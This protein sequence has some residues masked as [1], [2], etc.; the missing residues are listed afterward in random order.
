MKLLIHADIFK[1]F[2]SYTTYMV[3]NLKWPFTQAQVAKTIET[4]IKNHVITSWVNLPWAITPRRKEIH[5]K[6]HWKQ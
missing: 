2:F 5:A 1:L 4:G 3:W 6:Q